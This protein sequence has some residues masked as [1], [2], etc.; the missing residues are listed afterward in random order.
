MASSRL[1][2]AEI[3]RKLNHKFASNLDSAIASPP[4]N[5]NDIE[6]RA[7][8]LGEFGQLLEEIACET[9]TQVQLAKVP[10]EVFADVVSSM[11]LGAIGF[12]K[13][14]HMTIRRAVEL[15][16]ALVYL[17]D[18]PHVFWGWKECDKDLSFSEMIEHLDSKSYRSFLANAI[19]FPA[20][21]ALVDLKRLREI[22]RITSNTTHGRISTHKVLM[23]DGFS[24]VPAEWSDCLNL[25]DSATSEV[26]RLWFNRFPDAA[27]RAR[28]LVPA[29]DR[30]C[31]T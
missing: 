12:A 6:I 1:E 21:A 10:E 30:I 9:P 7:Q 22:Y 13:P 5:L 20:N 23:S 24:H 14:A 11:Y 31:T 18:L 26:I 8:I 2:P 15:G 17:W 28:Q 3:L 4:P 16:L 29:Y 27:L 25:L 19:G